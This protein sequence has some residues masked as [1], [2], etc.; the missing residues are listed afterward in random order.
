SGGLSI[1]SGLVFSPPALVAAVLPG[2][3]SVQVGSTATAF[4][5]VI[6][7]GLNAG[8]GCRIAPQANLTATFLYQTTDPATNALVGT[9]NTAVNIPAGALQT[10]LIAFTPSGPFDPIDVPL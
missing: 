3:R 9:A 8:L 4:A 10:F 1:P 2:S 6:N 5:T 7:A